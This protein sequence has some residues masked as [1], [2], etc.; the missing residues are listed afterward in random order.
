MC[1]SRYR[2]PVTISPNCGPIN[3]ASKKGSQSVSLLLSVP[4]AYSNDSLRTCS[5]APQLHV[6]TCSPNGVS[7]VECRVHKWLR[8]A[9]RFTIFVL[10]IVWEWVCARFVFSS[11]SVVSGQVDSTYSIC[12]RIQSECIGFNWEFWEP[13]IL[14]ATVDDIRSQ[15]QR[16]RDLF[17][18]CA[19]LR[20]P[21]DVVVI[22]RHSTSTFDSTHKLVRT[23]SVPECSDSS[24]TTTTV[25]NAYP[26]GDTHPEP[27]YTIITS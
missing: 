9:D 24:P 11:F 14:V 1:I 12:S 13:Q 5:V 22:D 21:I 15:C 4:D 3:A 26:S 19:D 8:I 18:C 16:Q 20:Q 6:Y 23:V 7:W 10:A 2:I 27:L 25:A 17:M